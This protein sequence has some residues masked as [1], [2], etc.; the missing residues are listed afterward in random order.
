[1]DTEAISGN[2]NLSDPSQSS[3]RWIILILLALLYA[4][5]GLVTR[6]VAPLVTPILKDLQISYSEMGLILGSW[7]LTFIGGSVVAG[8]LIDRWGVRKSLLVGVL[9]VA[10]SAGLRSLPK[11]F[12]GML[13]AVTLF[14]VGAPMIS[15]G[16]PKTISLWFKGKS[17]SRAVGIYLCGSFAGQLFSLTLTN[18]L[19]MPLLEHSWRLTFFCYGLICIGIAALWWFLGKEAPLSRTGETAGMGQTFKSW[20]R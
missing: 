14:G 20:P 17:R 6:S 18:S 13:L 19:M 7:Q 3:Y 9:I 2:E 8:L 16:C 5:F 1:M 12:T 10:L 11:D 15:I 4:S